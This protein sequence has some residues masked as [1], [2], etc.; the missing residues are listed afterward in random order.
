[1]ASVI[2]ALAALVAA[3]LKMSGLATRP[4]GVLVAVIGLMPA[5]MLMASR[6]GR[7]RTVGVLHIVA[8]TLLGITG[9]V[10]ASQDTFLRL[11]MA[12]VDWGDSWPPLVTLWPPWAGWR[13]VLR[14]CS[15]A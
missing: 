4:M 11:Q 13:S 10:L 5:A 8:G 7:R 12:T 9:F 1:M 6:P 3:A 14:W 15:P 2:A